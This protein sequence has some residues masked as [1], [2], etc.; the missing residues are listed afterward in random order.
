MDACRGGLDSTVAL[1]KSD[2]NEGMVMGDLNIQ[3]VHEYGTE[4]NLGRFGLRCVG[5]PVEIL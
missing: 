5:Y 1:C 3:S 2:Y 4:K